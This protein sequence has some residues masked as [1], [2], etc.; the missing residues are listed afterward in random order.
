M[1]KTPSD[2]RFERVTLVTVTGLPDA[3]KSADAL[4]LSQ[5]NMPGAHALLCSPRAPANL[6]GSVRHVRIAEMNYIEYSWFM[7]FAVWKFIDTDFALTVQDDG[8]LLD[9]ANWRDEYFDYDYIGAP[10]QFARV[11]APD[12][13]RWVNRFDW[14][15]LLGK[16]GHT[17]HP[18]LNGGFSLRSR[19][20][21]RLFADHPDIKVEIPRPDFL[22]ED[23][24]RL[25]WV[26]RAPNEDV[27]LSAIL[28]PKLEA[29]G[30][31]FAPVSLCVEFAAEDT[32]PPYANADITK[33]LG[34]HAPWRRLVSIDPPTVR[35]R[36]KRSLAV[37]AFREMEIVQM[38]EARG[39][40]V[41]FPP[42]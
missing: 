5:R 6:P 37:R 14:N 25:R 26:N 35:Y 39:Y 34:H 11:D 18:V 16:P 30:F 7:L 38:F 3:Q 8:W 31:R 13:P 2:A 10:V 15:A 36:I 19:R 32:G 9:S 21:L 33:L 41:E 28:R 29:L 42:E 23:P 4:V 27:Q 12:G 40:R 20:L 24:L 22:D 1:E 17:V